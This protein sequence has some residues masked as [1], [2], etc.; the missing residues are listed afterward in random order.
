M[1]DSPQ[2]SGVS[3]S[4]F[5]KWLRQVVRWYMFVD[6]EVTVQTSDTLLINSIMRA[7]PLALR[8][9]ACPIAKFLPVPVENRLRTRC[10]VLGKSNQGSGTSNI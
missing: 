7:R 9:Y 4:F 5:E 2:S 1:A 10:S 8:N 6:A 3:R